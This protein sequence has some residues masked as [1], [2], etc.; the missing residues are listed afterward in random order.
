MQVIQQEQYPSV[1]GGRREEPAEPLERNEPVLRA[2]RR[3]AQIGR[4]RATRELGDDPAQ[5]PAMIHV[6]I[7][8]IRSMAYGQP[9]PHDLPPRPERRRTV[10]IGRSTPQHQ[11][12][13]GASEPVNLLEQVGLADPRLPPTSANP[14]APAAAA[15]NTS[16]S[17]ANSPTRPTN[18][19]RS[20][21]L[22]RG[23]TPQT[24]SAPANQDRRTSGLA[25]IWALHSQENTSG[26]SYPRLPQTM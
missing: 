22:D 12:T 20:V 23:D 21:P 2:V 9:L 24:V 13:A 3:Q 14:V 15:L 5:Q 10:R 8:A 6:G 16:S 26:A 7:G 18:L 19:V 17:A 11:P 25:G 1:G 4:R